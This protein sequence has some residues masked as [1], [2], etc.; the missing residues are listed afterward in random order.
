MVCLFPVASFLNFVSPCAQSAT[1]PSSFSVQISS[2]LAMDWF[3][4]GLS[5]LSEYPNG[6]L[7]VLTFV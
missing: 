6:S 2:P 1:N 3:L 7:S 5:P 4:V